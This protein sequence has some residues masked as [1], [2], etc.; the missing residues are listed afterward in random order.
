M[1]RASYAMPAG[2]PVP[3]SAANHLR[4]GVSSTLTIVLVD[5]Q[6]IVRLY[7]PGR[8]AEAELEAI[9]RRLVK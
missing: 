7:H 1:R 8:I 6:G 4:Y 5:R 9:V 3:L 2:T